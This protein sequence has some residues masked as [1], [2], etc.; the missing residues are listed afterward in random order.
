M[1]EQYMNESIKLKY[2][3][4][5]YI[6]LAKKNLS[7]IEVEIQKTKIT[8]LKMEKEIYKLIKNEISEVHSYDKVVFSGYIEVT[9]DKS[10]KFDNNV[11]ASKKV[12]SFIIS[13]AK[14]YAKISSDYVMTHFKKGSF[15]SDNKEFVSI[16][17]DLIT[18]T[19]FDILKATCYKLKVAGLKYLNEF[20]EDYNYNIEKEIQDLENKS[21]GKKDPIKILK[22]EH[23]WERMSL[24]FKYDYN[25]PY[26]NINYHNFRRF[27][28]FYFSTYACPYCGNMLYKTV[29]PKGQ[30]FE[31]YTKDNNYNNIGLKRLFTC[32]T[33]FAFFSAEDRLTDPSVFVYKT[34]DKDVYEEILSIMN[35]KGGTSGRPDAGFVKY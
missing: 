20:L 30:E 16:V 19:F 6:K 26:Q 15:R 10:I 12:D 25:D 14:E 2:T 21:G 9:L 22:E 31:I 4:D 24:T 11:E 35:K 5:D 33:D 3:F 27:K 34:D 13:K 32:Y 8:E 28:N 1:L 29:F 18:D 17:R 23:K 7:N